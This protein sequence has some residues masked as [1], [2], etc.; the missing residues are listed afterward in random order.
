MSTRKLICQEKK[1]DHCV[2]IE[3]IIKGIK[4]NKKAK[5]GFG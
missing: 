4:E 1:K 3:V 5:T 2:K